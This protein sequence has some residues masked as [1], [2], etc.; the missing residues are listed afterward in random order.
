MIHPSVRNYH[1]HK[2]CLQNLY[3][4]EKLVNGEPQKERNFFSLFSVF[5][6]RTNHGKHWKSMINLQ[7]NGMFYIEIVVQMN[8]GVII[9]IVHI[10]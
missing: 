9:D 6:F 10:L 4:T 7:K 2:T 1:Q 8:V 5:I 3:K